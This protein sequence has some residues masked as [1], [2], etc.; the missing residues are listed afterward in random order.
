MKLQ[1]AIGLAAARAAARCGSRNR[2]GCACAAPAMSNGRCQ[3]HGGKSTGPKTAAGLE[4]SRSACLKHGQ[5]SAEV[6]EASRMRGEA[7]RVLKDLD[8]LI[9]SSS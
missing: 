4:R 1:Q 5:R 8:L 2:R 7:R 3:F 6:R 9:R